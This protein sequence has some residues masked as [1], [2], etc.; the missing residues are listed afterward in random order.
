MPIF[1][2]C[3]RQERQLID[4]LEKEYGAKIPG[5]DTKALLGLDKRTHF[6]GKVGDLA[7]EIGYAEPRYAKRGGK[8]EIICKGAVVVNV[9]QS[10]VI[11]TAKAKK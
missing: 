1:S 4:G 11:T 9:V 3:S 2:A 8:Y 7:I 5:A 6:M 10:P